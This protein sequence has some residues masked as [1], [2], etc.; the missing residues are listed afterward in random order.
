MQSDL[1]LNSKAI[2]LVG[3]LLS[4]SSGA[5]SGMVTVTVG[6]GANASN[7][8][9]AAP[10]LIVSPLGGD[11]ATGYTYDGIVNDGA[12]CA[13]GGGVAAMFQVCL[14][15]LVVTRPAGSVGGPLLFGFSEM[16]PGPIPAGMA[17]DHV[18]GTFGGPN[19][20]LPGGDQ[21]MWQG[22]A[23]AVNI[24]PPGP[25]G[26][27]VQVVAMDPPV[28]FMGG[29]G[30]LAVAAAP[31]LTLSGTFSVNLIGTDTVTL[32]NSAEVGFSTPEP[33]SLALVGLGLLILCRK[34]IVGSR[35]SRD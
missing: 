9:G 33:G 25:G 4:L 15:S 1:G 24:S 8:A 29:H 34:T 22:F 26:A 12:A 31:A 20:L 2:R 30:P 7:F 6:F 18:D 28:A 19:A 14:T 3:I 27:V 35:S 17:T 16:F 13:G 10:L 23:N 21:I 5:Y 11:A 32:P